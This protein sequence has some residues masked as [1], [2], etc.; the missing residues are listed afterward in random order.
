MRSA[1]PVRRVAVSMNGISVAYLMGVVNAAMVAVNAF[2][3][4]LNDT[5][6]VAIA[7]L[8]NASMILL[9]TSLV[10]GYVKNI[11]QEREFTSTKPDWMLQ[12]EAAARLGMVECSR[13]AS[14]SAAETATAAVITAAH[15]AS[16]LHFMLSTDG[17]QVHS[18]G[19][20]ANTD[21]SH[22]RSS[23]SDD[24]DGSEESATKRQCMVDEP[25]DESDDEHGSLV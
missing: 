18:M 11:G 10:D 20:H 14:S 25:V 5:Q 16:P 21:A 13:L 15:A 23:L 24:D 3:V 8:I 6:R 2:G 22:K 4:N 1:H 19:N 12:A 17:L 7:G 9:K